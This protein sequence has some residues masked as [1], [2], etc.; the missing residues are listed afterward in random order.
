MSMVTLDET[1]PARALN[2]RIVG[3]LIIEKCAEKDVNIQK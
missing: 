2:K 1:V 3:C